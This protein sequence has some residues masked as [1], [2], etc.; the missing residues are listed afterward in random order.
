MYLAQALQQ[1]ETNKK[2]SKEVGRGGNELELF[3]N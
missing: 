1:M 3:V 2:C